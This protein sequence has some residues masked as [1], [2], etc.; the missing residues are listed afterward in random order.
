MKKVISFFMVFIL[1]LSVSACGSK[2]AN[3]NIVTSL[4]QPV[5]IEFWHGLSGK[6]EAQ[7]QTLTDQFNEQQPNIT[8]KLVNQGSYNDLNKK[9]TVAATSNGLPALSMAYPQ[10]IFQLA[11]Q[12][13]VID[14]KPY[15]ENKEVGLD[16][17]IYFKPFIKEGELDGKQYALPFNKSTE[18][19][20]YNKTE[21]D[22]LGKALPTSWD[23]A[24]AIAKE[25]HAQTGKVGF[26]V[27][28][29]NS[30]F[31]TILK[32][33]GVD[34]WK[35][36]DGT[37]NFNNPTVIKWVTKFQQGKQEGWLRLPGEDK[38][39]STP[40]GNGDVLM[41]VGSNAGLT[42]TD[43]AVNGKFEWATAPYPNDIVIQ[44][45]PSIFAMNN[46]SPQQ[47]YASYE[48]MKFMTS[49]P[50]TT[51]WAMATGYLPVTKDAMESEVYKKYLQ[52]H[53]QAQAAYDQKDKMQ[54]LVENFP[55]SSE[56]FNNYMFDTMNSII[57]GGSD[58][59]TKL[60]ELNAKS[61]AAFETAE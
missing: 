47:Q 58:V 37:F 45:G 2:K 39:L 29:V 43:S 59:K 12:E 11:R 27:D 19:L 52:E 15:M 32:S 4:D 6:V 57:E 35:N 18:I 41:Y 54:I 3:T 49:T 1:M 31:V 36:E 16:E 44:Q 7:L 33:S 60:E 50:S 61:K 25:Y 48:Y 28:S 17:S 40:F 30:L 56:I 26:G 21:F 38:Y 42:F 13:K 10:L 51:S 53:P 46:V 23:E 5:E 8:V 14:V 9:L 34:N 55:G 24:F 22:K 20:T